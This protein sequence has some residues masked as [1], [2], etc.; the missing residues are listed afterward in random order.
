MAGAFIISRDIFEN[1]IWQNQTE[2]RLFFLILGKAMFA[3]EGQIIGNIHVKKGQWLR[4]YRNLQADLEYIENHAIKKPS[5][6]TIKKLIEKLVKDERISIEHTELGTLITVCN[7]CKYQDLESYRRGTKNTAE[8]RGR[9]EV[10]QI[11]NNNN[12]VNND[13]NVNNKNAYLPEAYILA[14]Y[15][16]QRIRQNNPGHKQPNLNAWARHIDLMIRKDKRE[17]TEI[18]AVIE[19]CQADHFWKANILSTDKLR[20]RYDQLNI[21]RKENASGNTNNLSGKPRKPIYDESKRQD[22]SYWLES[23][24]PGNDDP[25]NT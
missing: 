18:R 19:F 20:V 24:T 17:P 1:A 15:L 10:E 7:Y 16:L 9:T 12:N 8:N 4:S 2:F 25:N 21:R 11:A 6:S 22:E 23:A 3:E 14:D 13:N 5:L